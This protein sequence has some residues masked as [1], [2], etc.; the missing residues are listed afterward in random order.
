MKTM[1]LFLVSVALLAFSP[2]KNGYDVGDTAADFKLKNVDGKMV[3][4][5]DYKSAK[6]FIIAFDCNTCP[7][8]KAYN[9]RIQALNEKYSSKGFPLIAI[10]PNSPDLS[11]GDS[12][13]EMVRYSK[14]KGYAFPYLYDES[15]ATVRAFGATNTPHIFILTKDGNDYKVAYIGAID[16]NSRSENGVKT[17]YVED[18]VEA[19]L[20]G[21][22]V[23]KSKTKAVGC[24]VKLKNS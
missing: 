20:A 15:Q 10:N 4:L 2:A 18:A 7:V 5:A 3:S 14:K 16:D 23:E 22:A 13:D 21:K 12:F 19:L 9:E 11:S 24:G 8:S 6:G 1:V 17:R